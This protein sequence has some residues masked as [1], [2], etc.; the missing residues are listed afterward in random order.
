[1]YQFIDEIDDQPYMRGD[2]VFKKLIQACKYLYSEEYE[3]MSSKQR[4]FDSIEHLKHEYNLN[5]EIPKDIPE[6]CNVICWESSDKN[7]KVFYKEDEELHYWSLS[8]KDWCSAGNISIE[9]EVS[10]DVRNG[11]NYVYL[12]L[13][14]KDN[15]EA[16]TPERL[17]GVETDKGFVEGIASV[18]SNIY[19][20]TGSHII[21]ASRCK[22]YISD[23]SD[24]TVSFEEY[25]NKFYDGGVCGNKQDKVSCL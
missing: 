19:L 20:I 15:S 23:T 18:D 22:F 17:L 5:V 4:I 16:F 14:K 1:M 12:R 11:Y 9:Q 10:D 13:C 8:I 21:S 6:G 7:A 3:R 2:F 24:E 25:V